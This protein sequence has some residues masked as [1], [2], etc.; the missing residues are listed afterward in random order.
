MRYLFEVVFISLYDIGR[1][2]DLAR[3]ATII[4]ASHD[5]RVI[6]SRDTPPS[7]SIPTPLLLDIDRRAFALGEPFE[8]LQLQAKIYEDG[9]VSMIARATKRIELTQLHKVR[10]IEFEIDGERLTIGGW[11]KQRFERLYRQIGSAVTTGDYTLPTLEEESYAVFCLIDKVKDPA[12]LVKANAHYLAT[13]LLGERPEVALHDSQ[14]EST[15]G[16]PFSFRKSD[17]TIL[18]LDRC[19][20]IDPDRDYEDILLI[21]ELANYQLLELRALD[22]LLDR[23]LDRAE[24]DIND[25]YVRRRHRSR[26]M[27]RR[28]GRLLPLRLDALFILENL[29]NTS[30]IIGDYFLGQ[31]YQHLCAILN[32]SEWELSIRRRLEA[33]QSIYAMASGDVNERLL[34]IMEILVVLLFAIE[35]VALFMPFL[36][37]H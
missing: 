13:F 32:T 25:V 35:I 20:I 27:S 9:V 31:V 3:T 26:K 21:I 37:H 18:D 8:S 19:L 33:L 34:I 15:L 6:T 1:S 17:L 36:T 2:I 24:D 28:I 22:K 30:K 11:M 29:E 16:R 10:G 14:V 5:V 12:K 4:P 23:W 7:I